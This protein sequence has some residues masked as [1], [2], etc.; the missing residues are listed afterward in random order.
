M[1]T[2]A[3]AASNFD[4]ATHSTSSPDAATDAYRFAASYSGAAPVEVFARLRVW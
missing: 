2:H 4:G 1:F 3:Q